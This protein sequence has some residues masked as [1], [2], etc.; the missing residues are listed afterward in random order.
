MFVTN[1]ARI[2]LFADNGNTDLNFTQEVLPTRTVVQNPAVIVVEKPTIAIPATP[3]VAPQT[4]FNFVNLI[5]EPESPPLS[6]E[7]PP[8][9]YFL[10]KYTADDDGIFEESFKWND[11]NDDPDAIRSAIEK[12][13]LTN[14]ISFWPDTES[15]NGNWTEQIKEQNRV[16]PGLYYIFEVEEGQLVPE[17]VDAPVDRTDIENLVEPGE[18]DTSQNQDAIP[19]QAVPDQQQISES[20]NQID[21]AV[22]TKTGSQSPFLASTLLLGQILI[23]QTNDGDAPLQAETTSGTNIF[24][25]ASRFRRRATKN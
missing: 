16:K 15:Q 20:T 19:E 5:Q 25:R 21:Q 14:D 2:N 12:A 4:S 9:S 1:D 8:N 18:N 3:A 17:P 11:P 7:P 22:K 24:S 13:R 6:T 10:V 23:Q